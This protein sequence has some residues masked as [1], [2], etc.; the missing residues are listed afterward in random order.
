MKARGFLFAYGT[1]NVVMK[2]EKQKGFTIVE[3]L[4]V[5][6]VIGIL[7]AITIVAFNGVQDKAKAAAVQ[8]DLNTA[9]KKLYEYSL[10]NSTTEQ[11]P[12]ALPA[13]VTATS[14]NA[15]TYFPNLDLNT[16]CLQSSNGTIVSSVTSANTTPSGKPCSENSLI[17]WWALN[18]QATDSSE[19]AAHGTVTGATSTTGYGGRTNGA[20][21][22]DG[23]ESYILGAPG[24]IGNKNITVNAWVFVVS[25]STKGTVFHIGGGN[26]YSIGLGTLL[27]STNAALTGLFPGV[28]WLDTSTIVS[29]GWHTVSLT[30]DGA[31]VP[32]LYLDG[33]F[34][35][36][37]PGSSPLTA[38][39]AFSIGRNTGD[40]GSPVTAR[41]FNGSIDDVRLYSRALSTAE[42]RALYIAGAQ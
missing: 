30:L 33:V 38:A 19:N 13:T 12:S 25:G 41:R 24:S 10:T 21:I 3:L 11:Y 9:A 2:W 14:G 36:R 39:N 16:Y 31:A 26:G 35:A 5:I 32:S 42:L 37:L 6:V 40:E 18:G 28:R 27:S 23:G 1:I 29:A 17:G 8:V 22:F 4:I 20:Y 34:V 15:Y 7:A